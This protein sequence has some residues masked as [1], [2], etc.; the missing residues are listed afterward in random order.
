VRPLTGLLRTGFLV[1]SEMYGHCGTL[2]QGLLTKKGVACAPV[3]IGWLNRSR[4]TKAFA[5]AP[6]ACLGPVREGKAH[7]VKKDRGLPNQMMPVF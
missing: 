4:L 1:V 3:A 7:G 5:E 2:D 6:E